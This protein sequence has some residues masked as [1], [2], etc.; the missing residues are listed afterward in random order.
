MKENSLLCH[1][2]K[3]AV[4]EVVWGIRTAGARLPPYTHRCDFEVVDAAAASE[5]L[6]GSVKA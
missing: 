4:A 3:L 5:P 2:F 6:P 1:R